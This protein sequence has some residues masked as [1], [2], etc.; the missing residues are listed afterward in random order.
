MK[1]GKETQSPIE[2]KRMENTSDQACELNEYL[3][4]DGNLGQWNDFESE[5][6]QLQAIDSERAKTGHKG[7]ETKP[8]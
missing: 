5:G 1:R 8:G 3:C 7:D 6:Q 4:S 2:R